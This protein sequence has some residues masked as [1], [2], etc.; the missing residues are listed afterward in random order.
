LPKVGGPR[1]TSEAQRVASRLEGFSAIP[2]G[3]YPLSAGAARIM[4]GYVSTEQYTWGLHKV[5]DGITR[6]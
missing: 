4:A 2:A 3:T 6:T 5:L 1:G